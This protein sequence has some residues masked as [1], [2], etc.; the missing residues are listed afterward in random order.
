[1]KSITG[2]IAGG[3]KEMDNLASAIGD[4]LPPASGAVSQSAVGISFPT[5][6][7]WEYFAKLFVKYYEATRVFAMRQQLAI[8]WE[9]ATL[10]NHWAL[11][12]EAATRQL[13]LDTVSVVVAIA[14]L[15]AS[16]PPNGI[17]ESPIQWGVA[18]SSDEESGPRAPPCPVV[19]C[20]STAVQSDGCVFIDAFVVEEG[21]FNENGEYTGSFHMSGN[22][23][24]RRPSFV[25]RLAALPTLLL[26]ELSIEAHTVERLE[27]WG[28]LHAGHSSTSADI[29]D[30]VSD[31][32]TGKE[33]TI[34]LDA[35]VGVEAS[36]WSLPYI[37]RAA[38]SHL[39]ATAA[40]RSVPSNQLL[41]PAYS[42]SVLPFSIHIE[43]LR[44]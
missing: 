37:P 34:F 22:V 23:F 5:A 9:A 36:K 29:E 14:T 38:A 35:C 43:D 15:R 6:N 41:G 33:K 42:G 30:S 12:E 26:R 27:K 4:A 21:C 7:C 2:R 3:A 25:I 8:Q 40:G 39:L 10:H 31:S 28:P 1:M 11:A 20:K 16:M 18:R 17:G 24:G 19:Y 32:G 44:D 13:M